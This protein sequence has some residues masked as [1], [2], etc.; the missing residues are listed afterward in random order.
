MA[1]PSPQVVPPLQLVV[2]WPLLPSLQQPLLP[3]WLPHQPP[4]WPLAITQATMLAKASP[5]IAQVTPHPRAYH[6]LVPRRAQSW[7]QSQPR[8]LQVQQQPQLRCALPLLLCALLLP[9]RLTL[10]QPQPQLSLVQ[11]RAGPVP[12]IEGGR[13]GRV[14]TCVSEEGGRA[15]M[16]LRCCTFSLASRSASIAACN[17]AASRSA[18]TRIASCSFA[19]WCAASAAFA[20]AALAAASALAEAAASSASC[21]AWVN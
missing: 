20:A 12:V 5:T 7:R 9:W 16:C 19:R 6:S 8:V 13:E 2:P 17:S 10:V 21:R 4:A 15:S 18:F 1:P 14:A 3:C 11:H